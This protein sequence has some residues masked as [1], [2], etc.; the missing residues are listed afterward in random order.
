MSTLHYNLDAEAS[1]LGGIFLDEMHAKQGVLKRLDTLEVE[2][3]FSPKHQAVFQAIRNLESRG[4]P[5]DPVTV[6]VE[7]ERI[8]RSQA[9]GGLSFL[10]D[11]TLRVPSMENTL[12]YAQILGELRVKRTLVATLS[13][14]L[15]A[16][17]SPDNEGDDEFTGAA[18]VRWCERELGRIQT[19]EPST[20][21]PIGKLVKHRVGEIERLE[22]E[23]R[24]GHRTITGYTTGIKALDEIT[25]GFQPAIVSIVAARPAMGK[26]SEG[27]AI[28]DENSAAG[29]GVHVFNLEDS[30]ANYADRG[31]SRESEVPATD[32][33]RCDLNRDTMGKVSSALMRL[34]QRRGWLV[35]DT[36]DL[37]ALDVVRA[38]RREMKANGTKVVIVDYLQMLRKADAKMQQHD[39]LTDAM[40]TFA[41]AAKADKIAY[42]VMSQLNRGVEQRADKR[43]QLADL[44]ESGA[45]EERAKLVLFLYRGHYYGPQPQS[46]ID[47][48]RG[49]RPPTPEEFERTV[50]VIVGKNNFGPTG[51]VFAQWHG[52]TTTIR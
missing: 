41:R 3:F 25:G 52:P 46:G 39:H 34:H 9:V 51:R 32:I 21:V 23:R 30:S 6:D 43:P 40:T 16:V 24:L 37:T 2:D 47:F 11:L 18:A 8:G 29:I 38:V 36:G 35:D 26:S 20:A 15:A 31:L 5:I 12:H 50:Q 7:L 28:A 22:N 27:L 14:C 10:G 17:N 13:S 1:V 48:D 44:R 4:E 33:R 19:R 49:N 45:I 42:V